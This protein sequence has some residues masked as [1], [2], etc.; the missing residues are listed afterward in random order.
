MKEIPR[1]FLVVLAIAVLLIG[2]CKKKKEDPLHAASNAAPFV[3]NDDSEGFLF[4]WIDERGDFHVE[5]RAKDVPLAGRDAV[6]VVDPNHD[7][8]THGDR[9]FVA[10]LRVARPDGSYPM[11][12]LTRAEF[13][14][15]A[16]ARRKEHG[17]TLAVADDAGNDSLLRGENGPARGPARVRPAPSDSARAVV[18]IY[19]ASWCGAC[20]E[21][22]A[23]LTKK[24]IPFVEK[25][26]EEERGAYQEMQAK[27]QRAGLRGGSIPV[28]D[29]R[30]KVMVGFDPGAVE[31][32]LGAAL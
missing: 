12:A 23:W 30:G 11:K 1:A 5:Q 17:V 14:A 8:G 10:D 27:L 15:V 13:D 18:I 31:H 4:T 2:G 16:L 7:E 21:A 29:V 25:D 6:R 24:G 32:A 9:I 26:V 22:A 3:V 28:L 19:G 20:R